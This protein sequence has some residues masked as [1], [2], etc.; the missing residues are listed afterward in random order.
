MEI[1]EALFEC[2]GSL[3]GLPGFSLLLQ[4]CVP[5]RHNRFDAAGRNHCF[6]QGQKPRAQRTH[7]GQAIHTFIFESFSRRS[8]PE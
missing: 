7:H 8:Y 1:K 5:M 2:L 6:P 4:L 3:G